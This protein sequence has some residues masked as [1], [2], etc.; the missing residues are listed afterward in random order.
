MPKRI[1]VERVMK[2]LFLK[3]NITTS[4]TKHKYKNT[5]ASLASLVV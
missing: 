2:K 4:Y 3:G 1:K 5:G